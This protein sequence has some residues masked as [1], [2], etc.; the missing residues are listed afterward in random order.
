MHGLL[1]GSARGPDELADQVAAGLTP[2]LAAADGREVGVRAIDLVADEARELLQQTAVTTRHPELSVPLGR[3]ELVRAQIDGLARAVRESGGRAH[4]ALRHVS[5]PA[6][7]AALRPLA[8]GAGIGIGTYLTAPRAVHGIEAIAVHG[9]VC[10]IELRTLQAA[11]I[12]LPPRQLYT[13]EPL[14]GY[15]ARGLFTL[16][17][18][19]TLDPTV[20]ELL[21]RAAATRDRLPDCRIGVRMSAS[22]SDETV[23]ALYRMGFRRF[24]VDA[25]GSRPLQLALGQA[26]AG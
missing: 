15:L 26:A 7:A 8:D 3:P 18:R 9:D 11:M 6:E 13:A 24:A 5:D 1:E 22:A 17:P 16:D 14:D 25:A 19:R 20:A 10:W 4:L 2:L 21:A 23:T 12:G